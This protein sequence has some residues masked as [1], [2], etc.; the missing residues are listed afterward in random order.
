MRN[1]KSCNN[2]SLE[3]KSRTC[4]DRVETK[5][6]GV[7]NAQDSLKVVSFQSSVARCCSRLT[8]HQ[9]DSRQPT[10]TSHSLSWRHHICHWH[11]TSTT[12]RRAEPFRLASQCGCPLQSHPQRGAQRVACYVHTPGGGPFTRAQTGACGK[13]ILPPTRLAERPRLKGGP[14]AQHHMAPQ[15]AESSSPFLG[16]W[17]VRVL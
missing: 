13:K 10:R 12:P 15:T 14:G 7:W 17:C 8:T 11:A 6:E 9:S 3:V 16:C 2:M 4:D 1:Y 5:S